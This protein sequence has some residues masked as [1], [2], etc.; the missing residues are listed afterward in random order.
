MRIHPIPSQDDFD[1][2]CCDE[3]DMVDFPE[4]GFLKLN[5]AQMEKVH[6]LSDKNRKML[7]CL[8]KSIEY[9][10]MN[11]G[12]TPSVYDPEPLESKMESLSL[13]T[14]NHGAARIELC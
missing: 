6:S 9:I 2:L 11:G 10:K 1:E 4:L 8:A 3:D 7:F 14:I 5:S 12:R 13:A